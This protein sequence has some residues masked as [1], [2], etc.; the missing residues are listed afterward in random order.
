MAKTNY[1]ETSI[2]ILEGQRLH[3]RVCVGSTDLQGITS[4]LLDSWLLAEI[5]VTIKPD[6]AIE[7][8]DD[9]RGMPY[10]KHTSGVPTT[11]VI[12]TVLHAGGPK[13]DGA[14]KVCWRTR[15]WFICC[16]CIIL[17]LGSYCI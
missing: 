17:C 3:D 12:F 1:D 6:N 5:T 14:Y 10:K 7:V 11:Q 15:C 16:K 2:Q 8:L 4:P 13:G 9:G